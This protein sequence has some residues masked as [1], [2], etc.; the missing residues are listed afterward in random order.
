MDYRVDYSIL[1]SF[2]FYT[3]ELAS[4]CT[5]QE[6]VRVLNDLFAEFDRIAEVNLFLFLLLRHY[7]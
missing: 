2:L 1:I 5:A 7:F 6:L 3:I 4:K